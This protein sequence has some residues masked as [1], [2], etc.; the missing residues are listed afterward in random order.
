[1]LVLLIFAALA[2]TRI[3]GVRE[4]G[5]FAVNPA[6][7]YFHYTPT[8]VSRGRILAVHGLNSSKN[9][10]N[11]LCRGLADAGFEIYAIDLPGHG[12]SRA[13]FHA[14][15]SRE[16]V[17]QVLDLLGGETVVIGHSLGGGFLLDI[18]AERQLREMVLFSPA[19][20]PL[21]SLQAN[22]VLVLV[23][24]FDPGGVR[25]FAPQVAGLAADRVTVETLPWI[26]HSGGLFRPW[27]IEDVVEWLGG[28]TPETTI[29]TGAR[30]FFIA[31][32]LVTAITAGIL[33]LTMCRASA[34]EPLI[35]V[36]ATGSIVQYTIAAIT[37]AIVQFLIP[38][39]APLRLFA[40]DYLM[41]FFLLTGVLL[42]VFRRPKI[43]FSARYLPI[44]I[45]S[46]G[47]LILLALWIGGEVA[48]TAV[49]GGRWLRFPALVIMSLPLFLVDELVLRP[50]RPW[51]K[52]TAL[53]ITSR[54]V[55]GAV[56]VSS[57]LIMNR[58]AAFLVLVTHLLILYWISLWIA[59]G[60]VRKR[61]DPFAAALFA[62]I[63]Q[64][65]MFAALFVTQ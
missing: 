7:P 28:K 27:V 19:P 39:G 9:V 34:V 53:A 59:S 13:P 4:T 40:A 23:G 18:A 62:A 25:S 24:Q 15:E 51:W 43:T 36:N 42:L 61:T 33:A 49:T 20:T 14:L 8:G 58:T 45:A 31:M 3:S 32:M 38:I 5:V 65:W 37:A 12:D 26:G 52:A 60:L 57:V 21:A 35:T 29:H 56:A 64:G 6:V 48:H 63:V 44:A 50:M 17:A 30:L 10:M 22:R 54:A 47:Y 16:A 55:L 11:T 46:A 1:M 2:Y 41:G